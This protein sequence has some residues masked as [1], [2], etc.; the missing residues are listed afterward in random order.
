M[1]SD[2]SDGVRYLAHQGIIDPKRVCIVGASY[3]GYAALAGV[4][5][6]IGRV[7]LCGVGRGHFR[8][9]PV[10]QMDHRQ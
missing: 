7:S 10:S 9:A 6:E 8:L 1:Q 5:I 3:G 2:L 4:T